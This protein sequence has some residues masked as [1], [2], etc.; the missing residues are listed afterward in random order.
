LHLINKVFYAAADRLINDNFSVNYMQIERILSN[1]LQ[2]G[3]QLNTSVV[4]DRANF[5]LLLAL[6]SQDVQD[7]AQFHL[8]S[9]KQQAVQSDSSL[10]DQFPVPTQQP[11][12]SDL[13]GEVQSL[14]GGELANTHGLVA[15]RLR[16][17][18]T[19][20]PLS[21]ELGKKHGIAADVF[22]NMDLMTARRFSGEYQST[23]IE[24]IIPDIIIGQQQT[25]A[26]ALHII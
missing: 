14:E 3:Q 1:E 20:E 13:S 4:D 6:M 5:S 26:A 11:L 23:E 18:L 2:L 16:H 17:C 21:F 22:E 7:Q 24:R 10:Q 19:P 9:N 12:V 15:A 8:E 25:Y